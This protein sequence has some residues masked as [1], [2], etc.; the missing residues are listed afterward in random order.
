MWLDSEMWRTLQ[1]NI[2][3]VRHMKNYAI[4]A[5]CGANNHVF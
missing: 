2:V 1:N 3:A 5:A 4:V